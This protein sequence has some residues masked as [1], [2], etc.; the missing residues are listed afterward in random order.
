MSRM[1]LRDEVE[2]ALRAWNA[3]E[4]ENGGSPI[5]DFDC[6]P[7]RPQPEPVA[8]R[9]TGY[10]RLAELRSA[11]DGALASRLDADLAYLGAVLGERPPLSDYIRSTQGCAAAGWPDDYVEG[12]GEMARGALA[13]LDIG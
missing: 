6:F 7:H 13:D 10:R 3:Y 4:V 5:I 1:S 2:T 8:D 9:L 11:A 12:R